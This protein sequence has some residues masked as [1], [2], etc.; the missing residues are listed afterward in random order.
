[1]SP[2]PVGH[3]ERERRRDRF[4]RWLLLTG[5]RSVIVAFLT[6]ATFLLTLGVVGGYL[7]ARVPTTPLLKLSTSLTGGLLPFVTLVLTINQLALSMELGSVFHL[8]RRHDA[9]L[10]F[11]EKVT[12]VTATDVCPAE[13][14]PLLETLFVAVDDAAAT[15]ADAEES[16]L[17][18]YGASLA[19]EIDRVREGFSTDA[20]M[21]DALV[22]TR[23]YNPGAHIH[24]IERLRG[25]DATGYAGTLD[26]LEQL[27]SHLDVAQKYFWMVYTEDEMAELA[28][29]VLYTGFIALLAGMALVLGF[30][31]LLALGVDGWPL[32]LTVAA[33]LTLE[34]LPF[35]ILFAYMLRIATVAR[36]SA[37]FG[38]FVTEGPGWE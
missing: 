8:E 28:R 27:Q 2:P 21:F 11:R 15:L 30:D 19:S 7:P 26:E 25:E 35:A 9:M 1:M 13:P 23:Q 20:D 10:E 38:P 24:D 33:G 22:A 14:A 4:Y 32:A 18:E 3:D 37:G 12:S 16:D 17:A 36:T 34:A 5:D 29:L 31:R 6:G